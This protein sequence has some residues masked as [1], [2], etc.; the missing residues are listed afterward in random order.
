MALVG[1][2]VHFSTVLRR[3]SALLDEYA[4]LPA[5]RSPSSPKSERPARVETSKALRDS[6]Q[7]SPLPGNPALC[8]HFHRSGLMS[9]II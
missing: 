9:D 2:P 8:Y 3:T 4:R 6:F 1:F 7:P 5:W